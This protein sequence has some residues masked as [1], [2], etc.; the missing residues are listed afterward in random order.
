MT[1]IYFTVEGRLSLLGDWGWVQPYM[2]MRVCVYVV[3]MTGFLTF[4]GMM[5]M[6]R[7]R[8]D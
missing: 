8:K 7:G 2:C 3:R 4:G 6:R 1:C 5:R